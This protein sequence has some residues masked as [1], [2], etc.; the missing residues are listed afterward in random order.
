MSIIQGGPEL[1]V[2][3]LPVITI[4]T[5]PIILDRLTM[6]LPWC[7]P[8]AMAVMPLFQILAIGLTIL[9]PR[10]EILSTS[11]FGDGQSTYV[12]LSGIS[13]AVPQVAGIF[14]LG[15]SL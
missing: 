7:R 9:A 10:T 11:N 15:W 12:S 6:S 2:L 5:K 3:F 14:A 1:E 4:L 13:M 8:S